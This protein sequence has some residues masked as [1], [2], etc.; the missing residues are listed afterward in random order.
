MNLDTLLRSLVTY[1]IFTA[2][3]VLFFVIFAESGLFIGFFLPGDSLLFTSG[4]LASKGVFNIYVLTPLFII[5]AITG[6]SIGYTFGHRM[7]K[8]LFEKK[9]SLLFHKDNLLKAKEFYEKYGKKTIIIARFIPLIRTFAPIVAGIGDMHYKTFLA[10]NVIGGLLWGGGVTL[11]GY[12]LGNVIP[13]VDKY[14]LSIIL[15]IIFFSV[16][17]PVY[18]ILKEPKHRKQI[19]ESIKKVLKFSN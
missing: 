16:A 5:A 14:L 17:P 12:F 10:Y 1:G 3:V 18:H 8:K 4:F 2:Y 19:F 11:L 15:G 13:D 7:G 9:D 6:D